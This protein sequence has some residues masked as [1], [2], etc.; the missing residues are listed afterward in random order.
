M[1]KNVF[2]KLEVA[3]FLLTSFIF[4]GYAFFWKLPTIEVYEQP[5]PVASTQIQHGDSIIYKV[6][7]CRR[8]SVPTYISRTL[9]PVEE[10]ERTILLSSQI[11][12]LPTSEDDCN[13]DNPDYVEINSGEIPDNVPYWCY[14]LRIDA[15]YSFPLKT[16]QIETFYTEEVCINPWDRESQTFYLPVKNAYGN[17]RIAQVLHKI[18]GI[19]QRNN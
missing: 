19:L 13:A 1:I 11:S 17:Y 5:F 6:N 4:L 10:P 2:R 18:N 3:V 16:P 9:Q 14:H 15:T 8:T 12:N 7:F